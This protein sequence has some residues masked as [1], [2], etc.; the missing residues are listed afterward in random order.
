MINEKFSLTRSLS[1][2]P[3]ALQSLGSIQKNSWDNGEGGDVERRFWGHDIHG[4]IG[5]SS[6]LGGLTTIDTDTY[7]VFWVA[8][9]TTYSQPYS[10]GSDFI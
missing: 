2:R 6:P 7:Y 10:D 5:G 4:D 1:G 9:S 8:C 3:R